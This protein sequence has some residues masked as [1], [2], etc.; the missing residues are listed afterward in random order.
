MWFTLVFEA[1]PETLEHR[2]TD[3]CGLVNDMK[4]LST[5]FTDNP[6]VAS[7][8]IEIRGNILPKLLEYKGASGKMQRRKTRV[9]D[10]LRDDLGWRPRHKL[11]DT[12]RDTSLRENLVNEVI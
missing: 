1:S 10:G 11:D 7:V 12:R 5:S 8:F 6:G 9:S 3:F 2:V 4:V